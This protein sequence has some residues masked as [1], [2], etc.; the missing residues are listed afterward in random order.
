MPLA[1]PSDP[2]Y[3]GAVTYGRPRSGPWS[4][5]PARSS[6]GPEVPEV[7]LT[8][9]D[10]VAGGDAYRSQCASCHQMVGQGGILTRGKNVPPLHADARCGSSRRSASGPNDM[11]NFPG[12]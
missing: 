11:P 2:A 8:A 9:A 7:D 6:S 1:A 10:V 5:T 4:P 12:R 3:R